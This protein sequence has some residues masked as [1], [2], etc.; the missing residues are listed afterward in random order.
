MNAFK[1]IITLLLMLCLMLCAI[2]CEEKYDAYD[3]FE[4]AGVVIV[5]C[6]S[7]NEYETNI[8][9]AD[10]ANEMLG[11]FK[12]LNIDTTT[13]GEIGSAYLYMRFY[14]QDQ[15]TFLIFTIYDNG[16]CCLGEE[17][18]DFYT[19]TDGRQAYIDLCEFYESYDGE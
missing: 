12:K 7:G 4:P 6:I 13:E 14:N 5:D 8:D 3:N 10:F 1:K 16:S 17:Y 15:S 2:G 18:Q 11:E 9:N 19:V